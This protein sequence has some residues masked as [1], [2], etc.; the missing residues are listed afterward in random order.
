MALPIGVVSSYHSLN[1]FLFSALRVPVPGPGTC[2]VP[3]IAPYLELLPRWHH[4]GM[5][6][7]TRSR[8]SLV[9]GVGCIVLLAAL[10][11]LGD[12]QTQRRSAYPSFRC[13]CQCESGG[14]M[15]HMKFCELPKYAKRS[16][17]ASCHKHPA[18]LADSKK[19]AESSPHSRPS[20]GIL[21]AQLH[22]VPQK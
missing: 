7:V 21:D 17:A 18:P 19:P 20:R 1:R 8:I 5:A 11:L 12:T 16:W 10:P 4:P 15:C 6:R 2:Q 14:E 13:Y 22:S 3:T 9:A